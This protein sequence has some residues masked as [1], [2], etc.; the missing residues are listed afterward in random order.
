MVPSVL[1]LL[2]L[3]TAELCRILE[4]V[5]NHE[6]VGHVIKTIPNTSFE[7]CTYRCELDTKCI[8]VNYFSK[9]RKCEFNCASKEMFP[10]NLKK[11]KDSL[12]VNNI[13]KENTEI[14][15]CQW[16]LTC[17]HGG[18]CHPLPRPWCACPTGFNGSTCQS[19]L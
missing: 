6:L 1:V 16:L 2:F 15:P 9:I 18:S 14:D 19:K 7:K 8:S 3:H 17:M 12:Y 5:Q 10:G 4:P 13:R 11:K